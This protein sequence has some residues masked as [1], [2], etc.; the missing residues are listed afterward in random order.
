MNPCR[1][2][3]LVFGDFGRCHGRAELYAFGHL[4]MYFRL[5]C[6]TLAAFGDFLRQVLQK[7][8]KHRG[9]RTAGTMFPVSAV[10][11]LAQGAQCMSDAR[12]QRYP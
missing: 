4:P 5:Q 11:Y 1:V 10:A 9:H 12:G 8:E 7:L 2:L 3:A 6:L